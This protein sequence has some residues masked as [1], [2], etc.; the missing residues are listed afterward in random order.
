MKKYYDFDEFIC[1]VEQKNKVDMKVF[2]KEYSF[3]TDLPASTVLKYIRSSKDDKFEFTEKD[4]IDTAISIIG[5]NNVDEWLQKGIKSSALVE[6]FKVVFE[7][8]MQFNNNDQEKKTQM[9]SM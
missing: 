2:G 3:N 6:I 5:E 4:I 7:N 1:E 8:A 9:D